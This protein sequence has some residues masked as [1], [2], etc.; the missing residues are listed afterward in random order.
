MA[1]PAALLLV[2][3]ASSSLEGLWVWLLAAALS[4]LD[5]QVSPTFLP[6][7]M[8]IF[9][10]WLAA[11]VLTIS[12][13]SARTR[14]IVLVGG[15]LSLALAVATIQA[16][17]LFPMQLIL[18]HREPDFRGSGV[19][20]GLLVAYLWARGLAMAAQVSR[21]Q[22]VSHIGVS[23]FLLA[24]ILFVLPLTRPV[25]ESGL[26]VVIASFCAALVALL[27]VQLTDTQSRQLSK[28]QWFGLAGAAAVAIVVA[29]SVFT[30][31]LSSGA[32][33]AVAQGIGRG[34]RV[35][36]P[37]TDSILLGVGYL[38]HYLTY[39][40]IWLRAVFGGDPEA[41]E[42]AQ[43]EAERNR[44]RF[45][46]EGNYGPPEIMTIVAALI[47]LGLVAWWVA[48]VLLRLV[49]MGERR[50]GDSVRQIRRSVPLGPASGL[51]AAL[52]R[53]PGLGDPNHG[54]SGRA[55]QIRRH[56]RTFQ[57][58]MARARLPRASSQT[59]DEYQEHLAVRL[60]R[61]TVPVTTITDAYELARYADA[62]TPLPDPDSVATA[63][64]EVRATLQ[65]EA[66]RPERER[67][68][69]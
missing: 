17:V 13:V 1:R 33:G 7:A 23:I 49:G 34:A 41:V 15:G 45:E 9:I 59:A 58:M 46:T 52:A 57:A 5:G 12:R 2:V 60:P 65:D 14:R 27:L 43:Q 42:R 62:S 20:L 55:A 50:R 29:A 3:L 48:H 39:F 26:T 53:I 19:M 61:A 44:P 66:A 18:G 32:P 40:F 8:L 10:A 69:T 47:V 11:R 54:L 51:R 67:P 24:N 4:Q 31:I 35:T 68:G 30:G 63:L 16:G 21:R 36:T 56:Y 28:P 64:R 37:I 6:I 25:Q 22:V 38:A